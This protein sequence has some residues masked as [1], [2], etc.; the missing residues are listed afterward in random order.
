M[1][2]TCSLFK[3]F[4]QPIEVIDRLGFPIDLLDYVG[5]ICLFGLAQTSTQLSS[6]LGTSHIFYLVLII[7][8]A[9]SV[10]NGCF[11]SDLTWC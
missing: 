11:V 1:I 2:R 9:A 6:N 10:M 4:D 5:Q 8:M 3:I 7:A